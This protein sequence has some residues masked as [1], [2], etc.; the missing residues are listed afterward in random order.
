ML[1]MFMEDTMNNDGKKYVYYHNKKSGT[2][3]VIENHSYWC[4]EKKQ[5]RSKR[6]YV[7]TLDKVTNEIIPSKGRSRKQA[8][9]NESPSLPLVPNRWLYGATYLLN[10]IAKKLGVVDDLKRCFP[11]NY[12]K[13]LSIAYYLILEDH[14]PLSRFPNWDLTHLHPHGRA[15]IS[16]RSSDLFASITDVAQAKFFHLQSKRYEEDEYYLYDIT[17]ISSYSESLLQVQKGHNKEKKP[18]PQ[19]N[20][21]LVYTEK[22][23][24]PV[25]FRKLPGNIPDVKTVKTLLGVLDGFGYKK[26]KLDM[27]RGFYSKSNVDELY[28]EG[29]K[30]M[31]ATKTSLKYVKKHIDSIRA[32]LLKVQ[33]YDVSSNLYGCTLQTNWDLIHDKSLDAGKLLREKDIYIH[34]YYNPD[35]ALESERKLYKKLANLREELDTGQYKKEN[36]SQYNKYFNLRKESDK[37]VF[38]SFKDKIIED[39]KRYYGYFVLLSN[40]VS[41]TWKALSL[42]RNRDIIEK[43]FNNL[44]DRLNMNRLLVSSEMSLEGKLFVGFIALI[45]LA[46]INKKMVE[47]DL[48]R[49][50]TMRDLLDSL[51]RIECY[52]YQDINKLVIGEVL[53]KQKIILE[54]MDVDPIT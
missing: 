21:A 45:I 13:I 8:L 35:R 30:F 37:T 36:Q 16:Q 1:T 5:P 50:Y 28:K 14:N 26:A 42:Y 24:V 52:E 39:E 4:K 32:G 53:E 25:Y 29:F 41:D 33:N 6:K 40:E 15:I 22:T 51:E 17:T 18:L 12:K 43:G 20:L 23:G 19:L 48:Y 7:G 10:E 34:I 46:Y 31:L 54:K 47:K 3:Y 49:D 38:E 9:P 2:I 27:D 11:D 44:K